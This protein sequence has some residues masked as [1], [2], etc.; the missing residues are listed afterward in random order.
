MSEVGLRLRSQGVT[1][2]YPWR[3]QVEGLKSGVD[4]VVTTPGRLLHHIQEGS[5]LL[6]SVQ[7]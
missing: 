3:T 1:G 7:R 6:N 5:L 4:V 2:G